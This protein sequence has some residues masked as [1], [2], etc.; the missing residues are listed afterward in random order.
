METQSEYIKLSDLK[1]ENDS[2]Y[3]GSREKELKDNKKKVY[4][5]QPT[6]GSNEVNIMIV[7]NLIEQSDVF[8]NKFDLNKFIECV[9][10]SCL[11]NKEKIQ[12][13][14][15]SNEYNILKILVN[16]KINEKRIKIGTMVINFMAEEKNV[17]ILE[18][19]KNEKDVLKLKGK[20]SLD[21]YYK[22]SK[23]KL[24]EYDTFI[25]KI[26]I[27]SEMMYYLNIEKMSKIFE[28]TIHYT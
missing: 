22:T 3:D 16:Q 12:D 18:M 23:L 15:E 26:D 6:K 4:Q 1:K 24:K 14:Y 10:V 2:N 25:G 5:I 17:E 8:V 7:G 21:Y 27:M 20:F 11:Y 28:E 19:L 13:D 9:I